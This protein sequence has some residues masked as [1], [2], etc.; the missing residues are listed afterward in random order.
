MSGLPLGPAG[1]SAEM[2]GRQWRTAGMWGSAEWRG[3][4]RGRGWGSTSAG[5]ARFA[6]G[7]KVMRSSICQV[8]SGTISVPSAEIQARNTRMCFRKRVN[9]RIAALHHR[10][11]RGGTTKRFACWEGFL[12]ITLPPAPPVVSSLII[13]DEHCLGSRPCGRRCARGTAPLAGAA[14]SPVWVCWPPLP[15]PPPAD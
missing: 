9:R 1:S 7:S 6:S 4:R 13:C 5:C 14:S 3:R 8:A 2:P 15:P 10:H 11:P 12:T